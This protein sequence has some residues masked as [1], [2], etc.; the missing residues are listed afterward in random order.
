MELAQ[1]EER[2]AFFGDMLLCCHR[3][4]L[5]QYDS[6]FYLI[7]SNC[8]QQAA[9]NNLFGLLHGGK[10]AEALD[11]QQET[12]LLLTN[13]IG[14]MWVTQPLLEDGEL[15][16]LYVLGP[17][18]L[19]DISPKSFEAQLDLHGLT[20]TLRSS[21][22]Q[23]LQQIPIVSLNRVFEYAI[24]LHFCVTGQTIS[25]SDL[26][27]DNSGNQTAPAGP[28]GQADAH[29]TYEAEQEM[30]RIVREGDIDNYRAHMDR[31]AVTGR[32]GKLSNDDPLRQMKNAVITCLILF[33]RAA[34]EG[35][36]DPEVS[37]TLSDCYFQSIEACDSIPA[38]VDIALPM[39]EDYIQRVHRCRTGGLSRPVQ[40]C[41]DYIGLHLEEPLDLPTLART[42]GYTEYYLSSKFKKETG[43]PPSGYIRRKRLERAAHLLRTT[44]EDIQTISA[45]LQ[46]SSQS[47]FSD[48]FRKQYG[49]TPSAYRIG[50]PESKR[51]EGT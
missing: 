13:S 38:L 24:M 16:R 20:S 51:S 45:R 19:D 33:S 17:V 11:H 30:I 6:G 27:Y 49:M 1:I 5:W 37:Y 35:G 39:Q 28:T 10:L 48:C 23:F 26:R 15:V 44:C 18:F 8:P 32:M 36:L 29:G 12:P 14:M 4:Y 31:I 41:C 47:H 2:L 43:L 9:V 40:A 22:R 34:M 21:A 3:I 25:T 42:A 7:R 46:F 50:A